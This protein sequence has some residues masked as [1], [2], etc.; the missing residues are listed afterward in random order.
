MD[1][2]IIAPHIDDELLG[3]GGILNKNFHV[4]YCGYDE[5]HIPNR[6]L[7]DDRLKEADKVSDFLGFSYECLDNKIN[8]YRVQELIKSFEFIINKHKPSEVYIP[9]PSYNQDHN[10]VYEA[11]LIALRPHDKNHFV[12]TVLVYEQ[13]QVAL[14]DYTHNINSLFNPN[15]FIPIDIE[16]KIQAYL[17]MESQVR[18]FRSSDLLRSMATIRGHQSNCKYAEAFQI[19]RNVKR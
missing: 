18:S 11:S 5:S 12:N 10:N 8:D 2:L 19:L 9:Y 6:P 17:L 14:W 3:C 4:V 13:P 1:K 15:Y 7:M 16:R